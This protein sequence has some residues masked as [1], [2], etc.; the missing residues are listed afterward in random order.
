MEV[1]ISRNECAEWFGVTMQTISNYIEKGFLT[2]RVIGKVVYVSK[3]SAQE[4]FDK[5]LK[6]VKAEEYAVEKYIQALKKEKEQI[7]SDMGAINLKLKMRAVLS[8]FITSSRLVGD[9]LNERDVN[10]LSDY[11]RT[12][13]SA[14]DLGEKYGI[15]KE[16]I[17]QIVASTLQKLGNADSKLANLEEENRQLYFRN[18]RQHDHIEELVNASKRKYNDDARDR[19][20][21]GNLTKEQLIGMR[22]P[23]M[24]CGFSQRTCNCL[25]SIGV[26]TLGQA[27]IKGKK[28]LMRIRNFG[29]ISMREVENKFREYNVE[30][31]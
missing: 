6:A 30:L 29:K 2:H 8:L 13:L 12:D 16:R 25:R 9:I 19:I 26:V 21:L 3:D 10:V 14:K 15:T 22:M 7:K 1:Y 20:V 27:L 4:F 11:I 18:V 5:H 28:N 23:V 31:N 24:E 17:N